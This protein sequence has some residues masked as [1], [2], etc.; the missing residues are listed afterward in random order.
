MAE[1]TNALSEQ[2]CELINQ[3][4]NEFKKY[5][6]SVNFRHRK[7]YNATFQCLDKLSPAVDPLRVAHNKA[8]CEFLNSDLKKCEQFRN[9]LTSLQNPDLT[10]SVVDIKYANLCP[11]YYNQAVLL[12]HMKQPYSALKI[13]KGILQHIDQLENR[14]LQKV[15]LL[16]ACLLLDTNQAKKADQLIDMLQ[17]R[18]DINN[19]DILMPDDLVE[20]ELEK[21]K[22]T[23]DEEE[24]IFRNLFRLVLIRSYLLN[25]KNAIIPLEETSN[26]SILKAH[27][28][29]LGNDFQMASRELAKQF[30]NEL[31]TVPKNGEDQN[32][33]IANNMGLIHFSV[34]HY[35]LAVR[36]FQQAL[37]FDQKAIE[38]VKKEHGNQLPMHCIGA[39]KRQDILYN[40]G[41]ALLYLQRPKDAFDCLLVPL[42]IY[43]KNPKLWL[44]L[45]EACIMVH[46]QHL[47]EQESQNKNIV[48]SIIGSGMHRKFIITPTPQ[49]YVN[50]EP[51]SSAIPSPNLEFA[52]LCLRNALTLINYYSQLA[53]GFDSDKQGTSNI[54]NETFTMF[55]NNWNKVNE[56]ILCNPSKPLTKTAIDKLKIHILTASSYVALTLGDYTLALQHS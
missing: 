39:T 51:G 46:K 31:I 32:V 41:I 44:R 42:N 1:K 55:G 7:N 21:A 56:S 38:S 47:K 17:T 6:H 3:I 24:E 15:G 34:K 8:V 2:D 29:F 20:P 49:K 19:D 23:L 16:T 30:K 26:F 12:F 10:L 37:I 28:F 33:C 45:A 43:H 48:S 18:L 40:L 25:G 11:I 35:A 27:Q 5:F 14:F 22:E 9:A 52:S 4:T 50:D 13:M 36:F 54:K 53:N